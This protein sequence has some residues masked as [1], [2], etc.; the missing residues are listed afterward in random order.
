MQKNT[1]QHMRKDRLQRA[2]YIIDHL[3]DFGEVIMEKQWLN[4]DNSICYRQLTN[5]GVIIVLNAEK[6]KVVTC[7]IATILQIKQMYFGKIPN[8][9]YKIATKNELLVN[10]ADYQKL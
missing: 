6:T 1:T 9:L 2:E 3:G 5:K 4:K 8:W 7:F 10:D